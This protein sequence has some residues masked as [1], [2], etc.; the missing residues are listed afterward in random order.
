MGQLMTSDHNIGLTLFF[1]AED[2]INPDLM[3]LGLM[4]GAT[5]EL[6]EKGL[7][8]ALSLCCFVCRCGSGAGKM[9]VACDDRVSE[10]RHSRRRSLNF[11][12]SPRTLASTRGEIV[13]SVGVD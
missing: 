8:R 12:I 6:A 13:R 7:R 5:V 3:T 10:Y 1:H 2:M 9:V 4:N 11:T